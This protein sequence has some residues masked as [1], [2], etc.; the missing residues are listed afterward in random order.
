[1]PK[2]KAGKR[3]PNVKITKPKA[4]EKPKPTIPE[5]LPPVSEANKP[6]AKKQDDEASSSSNLN[7]RK[8]T[9]KLKEQPDSKASLLD[10]LASQ[11]VKSSSIW[12]GL[13]A[14]K[15]GF[16]IISDVGEKKTFPTVEEAEEFLNG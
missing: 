14:S 6:I 16:V 7:V 5:T 1:M 13:G 8:Q 15:E 11:P 10:K 3:S 12:R 9:Q 4:P 2:E